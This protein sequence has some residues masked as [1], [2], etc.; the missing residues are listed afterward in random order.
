MTDFAEASPAPSV[1]VL[2]HATLKQLKAAHEYF[3]ARGH[4]ETRGGVRCWVYRTDAGEVVWRC[5]GGEQYELAAK[6]C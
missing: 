4:E 6:E 1:G 2:A 3:S 5:I